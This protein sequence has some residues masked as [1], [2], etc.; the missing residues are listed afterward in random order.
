MPLW[1]VL[2]YYSQNMVKLEMQLWALSYLY[3]RYCLE[4]LIGGEM[5]C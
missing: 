1:Y 2:R 4:E 5:H 3:F